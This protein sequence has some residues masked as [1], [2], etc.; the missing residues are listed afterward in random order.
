MGRFQGKRILI[1]GGTSGMGLAGA[2]RIISEGGQVAVT[3]LSAERLENARNLLP[4]DSL[5]LSSDAG[6]EADI[7]ELQTAISGWGMLDGLW[8]NAGFAEVSVP[9]AVTAEAFSRMMNVNVRGPMLQLAVLSDLL[10]PA[11]SVLVT[12]SSSVYEGAAMTSLYAATKGAVIAMAKSWASALAERHIRVNTLIPG[13]IETNFRHFMPQESRQQFED[14]VVSQVPLGR[15]GTAEEAA[16]VALFLL[17]DDASYVTGS[18][19]A[20]DG[21]LIHY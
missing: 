20:V 7:S 17:S 19:Y 11:A 18:Q 12:S 10:N 3:G 21:G 9:E 2:L 5:V 1:T 8:L 6:S 15:A 16:A 13:P 14:F 4:A